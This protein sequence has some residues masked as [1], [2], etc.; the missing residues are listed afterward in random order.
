[1]A[2][3]SAIPTRPVETP[4]CPRRVA[5]VDA[6][7]LQSCVLELCRFFSQCLCRASAHKTHTKRYCSDSH[8]WYKKLR[9]EVCRRVQRVSSS[10]SLKQRCLVKMCDKL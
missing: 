2:T 4:G 8:M 3:R 9:A 6:H 7:Q 10:R 5:T 1:M